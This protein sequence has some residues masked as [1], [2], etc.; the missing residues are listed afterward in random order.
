[1][2]VAQASLTRNPFKPSSTASAAYWRSTPVDRGP[3]SARAAAARRAT[4]V[5]H[6][7]AA[8]DVLERWHADAQPETPVWD[9]GLQAIT[10]AT[11]ATRPDAA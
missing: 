4:P 6:T 9:R 10:A 11:A 7:A 8:I 2:S 1:M 3:A 5:E